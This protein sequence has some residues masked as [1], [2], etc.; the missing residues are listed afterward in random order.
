M[1]QAQHEHDPTPNNSGQGIQNECWI[2]RHLVAEI[3][4]LSQFSNALFSNALSSFTLSRGLGGKGG[5]G[6]FHGLGAPLSSEH[7]RR[8]MYI[9]SCFFPLCLWDGV[10]ENSAYVIK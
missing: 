3:L 10:G 1:S 5:G 9:S 4:Q 2:S 7:F 6:G 8:A